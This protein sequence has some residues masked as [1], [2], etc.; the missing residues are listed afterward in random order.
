M[1]VSGPVVVII[2]MQ[3]VDG[4]YHTGVLLSSRDR[5]LPRAVI[6]IEIDVLVRLRTN[7]FQ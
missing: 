5:V 7:D 1:I 4:P 2:K 3:M 6:C